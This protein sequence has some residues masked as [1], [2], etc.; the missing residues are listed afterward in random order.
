[1][2]GIIA[3][4]D[5]DFG[6][7]HTVLDVCR[8]DQRKVAKAI[9][10]AMFQDEIDTDLS[11]LID[12]NNNILDVIEAGERIMNNSQKPTPAKK[13]NLDVEEL[14]SKKD[15][16]SLICMLRVQM[17]EKRLDAAFA[18]MRFSRTAE[19]NQDKESIML[20]DEIRSSGGLLSLLTLFR[21]RG[22]LHELK[23]V[24][25]LAVA[26]L[27]PSFVES[28]SHTPPSLCLRIVECL[29]FLTTTGPI[30]HDGEMLGD[31]EM[32]NASA[33]AL[34]SFWVYQLE[35]IL[36]SK[37]VKVVEQS[38]TLHRRTS[39]ER[40][41]NRGEEKRNETITITEL[42]DT[43][44]T[45]IMYFAKL[46]AKEMCKSRERE[47]TLRWSYTLVEQ[48]CAVE[49]ARPI[50]VREG[51]LHVL[52]CWIQSQDRDRIRTATSALRYITSIHDKYMAGWIHSEMINQGAVQC[53]A[54]LTR[55]FS[56]TR[57]VR[58]SIAQIL[59]SL[60]AAPHTRAAVVETNCI[61]FL[62]GILYEHSDP[63]SSEVAL[64]AVQ[65]ILQLAAGAISR[66]SAFVGDDVET[67]GA[68]PIDKR[69]SLIG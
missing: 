25:A 48:V 3:S 59:S 24:T 21:T 47:N 7:L 26:Y 18:L 66:A 29:R 23:S 42:L 60:C 57:D 67:F 32:L 27:L 5:V 63:T 4:D 16:F 11:K 17:N 58:L 13:S 46:E 37:P 61:N 56:L 35:P 15:I 2:R 31:D 65:A 6:Y 62:I 49:V 54:D 68:T 51:V 50:A 52:V 28:S 34:A 69:D 39:R 53:L 38:I 1:V 41:R 12:L 40:E 45:L 36:I 33:L 30:L 22:I 64:F 10:D 9:E 20:R 14:V 43:T 8:D 55:D 19:K 44:V